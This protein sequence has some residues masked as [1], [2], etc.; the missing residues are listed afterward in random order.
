MSFTKGQRCGMTLHVM[1]TLEIIEKKCN[2]ITPIVNNNYVEITYP[3]KTEIF[4]LYLIRLL[5]AITHDICTPP[6]SNMFFAGERP[7]LLH[8]KTNCIG[9]V[10]RGLIYET[11]ADITGRAGTL[12]VLSY[13]FIYLFI[14]Y[15]MK[16]INTCAV[17]GMA[18]RPGAPF[19]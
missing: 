3:F 9:I 6:N 4:T 18:C 1:I 7:E 19:Y 15:L 12:L 11:Q 14:W 8:Y 13:V 2:G 17:I 10:W 16:C 5:Q